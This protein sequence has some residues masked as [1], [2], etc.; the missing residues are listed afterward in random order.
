[1][2]EFLKNPRIEI[3]E[4]SLRIEEKAKSIIALYLIYLMLAMCTFS[5]L[6]AIDKFIIEHLYDYSIVEKLKSQKQSLIHSYG[7]YT[8]IVI[9]FIGP[10]LEEI[11]FRLPLKLEKFGI[12]LSIALVTYRFS[13]GHFYH[14]DFHQSSNYFRVLFS[15][16]IVLFVIK[17]LPEGW[18]NLIKDRFFGYFF[19]CSIIIFA[20]VHISNLAPYNNR[21]ILFYPFFTL[22]YLLMGLFISYTRMKYGFVSGW[23]FHALINLPSVFLN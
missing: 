16:S 12:G 23:V 2:L 3:T 1:M 17:F 9:V 4:T 18:R 8:P 7:I 15:L 10:F 11:I 6:S 5:I 14:F 21:I 19:Y 20:I 13:G 22:P